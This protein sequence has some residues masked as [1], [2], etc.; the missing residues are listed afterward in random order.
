[1]VNCHHADVTATVDFQWASPGSLFSV[2]FN[3][4]IR[5]KRRTNV[6]IKLSDLPCYN[7]FRHDD[8]SEK[9]FCRT[10]TVSLIRMKKQINLSFLFDEA[11]VSIAS[12]I[13][14]KV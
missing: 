2:S 5:K 1:M 9:A 3:P 8:L 7:L 13:L 12:G 6:G 10:N 14:R 11:V 4:S